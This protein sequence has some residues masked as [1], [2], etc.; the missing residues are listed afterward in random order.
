MIIPNL[1]NYFALMNM[2]TNFFK[3]ELINDYPLSAKLW[4]KNGFIV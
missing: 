3:Q 1:Q 2:I 4:M